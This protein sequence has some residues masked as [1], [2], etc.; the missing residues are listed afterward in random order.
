MVAAGLGQHLVVVA[1]A[2]VAGPALA[3]GVAAFAGENWFA[4]RVIG[5]ACAV[6]PQLLTR[7]HS[8]QVAL[9]LLDAAGA[10]VVVG[11]ALGAGPAEV[12]GAAVLGG[13]ACGV[14]TPCQLDANTPRRSARK[15]ETDV[16]NSSSSWRWH[17]AAWSLR[18]FSW[19][20]S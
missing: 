1:Q 6:R 5:A 20:Q 19:T 15:R 3:L 11:V 14:R 7:A 9:V 17:L 10:V 16:Q 4:L 13:A 12:G 8:A 2:V 18:S